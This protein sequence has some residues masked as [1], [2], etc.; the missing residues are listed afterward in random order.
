VNNDLMS[1]IESLRSTLGKMEMALGSISDA[2]V[3]TDAKGRI[4]WCNAAFDR[5]V[6]KPHIALLGA[7]VVD[8]MPLKEHGT[9]IPGQAHPISLI[10]G[11]K[12]D[13]SGYYE[14]MRGERAIPLEIKGRYMEVGPTVSV[15]VVARDMTGVKE[16]EQVRLQSR[17]LEAA[18]NAIVLTDQKG[19]VIWLN[20]AFTA[21]TG[22]S[23][24]E[25][26]GKTLSFLKSG[27]HN[28]SFY[29]NLWETILSGEIWEDETLNRKKDGGLYTEQQMITP[30]RNEDGEI[31]HFIAVKQDISDRK[32]AESAL[33]DSESRIRNILDTAV[34]G[35]ITAD[36]QGMIQSFNPA[37]EKLFGYSSEEVTG[38]NVTTLMPSPYREKHPTY[39]SNYLK[40]GKR[41][42]I[43]KD[44]ETVARR[45]D[46]T[47]FPI[48]LSVSEMRLGRQRLFTGIIRD[49][50]Q[51]KE[52]EKN[53][54]VAKAAAEKAN[55]AKS[56]FL[57]NMS[58]EI[59]TPM[60]SI[61]G[62][63]EI[64]L[65]EDFS[66]EQREALETIKKSSD[67]LLDL[68]NEIL[69]LSKIE[70][71]SMELEK[72]PFDLKDLVLDVCQLIR[73]VVG[74]KPI[75]IRCAIEDGPWDVVTGDPTRIRQ[76]LLNLLGNAVKFTE[77]G[78]VLTSVRLLEEL[79]D[80]ILAE[81]AVSDTGVGIPAEKQETVF[82]AFSQADGS[83]TRKYG[84]TGLG[85]TISQRLIRLMEG[86]I[87]LESREGMGSTFS[88]KIRLE[89]GKIPHLS[90]LPHPE[91]VLHAPTGE[92]KSLKILLAEDDTA[93]Q[94]LAILVL[95]KMGHR[96]DLA[97]NGVRALEMGKAHRYDIILMDIQMPE[98]GGIEATEKLRQ[99]EVRTPIVAMTAS[100]MYGDRERFVEAG[101]DDYVAKPIKRE[102]LRGTLKR[103]AVSKL[104]SGATYDSMQ[105]VSDKVAEELGLDQEQYLE[106][107][108][109]FIEEK[110]KDMEE[111]EKALAREDTERIARLAHKI[112]GS[113]LN[114][115]LDLMAQP[116]ASIE[117]AAKEGDLTRISDDWDALSRGFEALS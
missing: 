80:H 39:M 101:M 12:S 52:F 59:R 34:D 14:F 4:Q 85:L 7:H 16:M 78:E 73:P 68:I 114:L 62:F 77:K 10:L 112:K 18:A 61:M 88:F 75:E 96:V 71:D 45:K 65:D 6:G 22:Y 35:I 51:R 97:I 110:K 74:E 9:S 3:W 111:L 28:E 115:R 66:A 102:V 33:R 58:H 82:A 100:V 109:G 44:Q 50:T 87:T 98:M 42:M 113:A 106:I 72:I 53:I 79:D 25:V 95:E 47:I 56:E 17:A 81:I 76:V 29:G 37:A 107:L 40:T 94:K 19:L 55:Q 24:D 63:T 117:K 11:K 8:I 32:K 48:D 43:G 64:L 54:L 57:A 90:D 89:K 36:D 30:V 5:L 26:Y 60:N 49:I 84:G 103:H 13:K 21:L 93:N 92:L 38:L 41:K 15:V 70:T 46:G 104:S 86:Q 2:I 67:R 116:A 108:T 1:Q 83:T 20:R 69:D 31:T 91:A 99:A 23:L 105:P 27:E